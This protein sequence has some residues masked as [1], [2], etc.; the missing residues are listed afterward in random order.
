MEGLVVYPDNML[1]NMDIFGGV[2]FSQSVMLKL[3][4]KGLLRED[5][6]KIVQDNAMAAWNKAGGDF[7]GNLL[8]DERV[9]K[10]LSE[11]EVVSCFDTSAYLKNIGHVFK[12]VGV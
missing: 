6:Y 2:I 1:A 5:A 8:G 11:E 3:I 7:R 4:D 12:R 10:L 9:R